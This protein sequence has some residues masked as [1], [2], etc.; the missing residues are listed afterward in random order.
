MVW[1][2]SKYVL[3]WLIS[4]DTVYWLNKHPEAIN[5][6]LATIRLQLYPHILLFNLQRVAC[7]QCTE[8]VCI[9]RKWNVSD[10]KSPAP[11]HISCLI[12]EIP[13]LPL[14]AMSNK[15]LTTSPM[16]HSWSP[17]CSSTLVLTNQT[18]LLPSW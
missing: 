4:C 11:S 10:L 9:S 18:T 1:I 14:P 8:Y 12:K 6:C 2:K 13:F 15:R 16:Y 5:Q 17:N 3:T 7:Q